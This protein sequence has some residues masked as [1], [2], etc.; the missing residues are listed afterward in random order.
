M[1]FQVTV[2]MATRTNP[3][4]SYGSAHLGRNEV[5]LAPVG[6]FAHVQLLSQAVELALHLVALLVGVDLE[7]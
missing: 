1:Y 2:V 4:H 6:G 3:V 7:H 5:T